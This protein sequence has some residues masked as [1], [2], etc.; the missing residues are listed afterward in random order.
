[1]LSEYELI[2]GL[3][4][5]KEVVFESIFREYYVRLCNFAYSFLEDKDE[6]EEV[7]QST[8]LSI[9]EK[10][11]NIDIQVSIKSYLY[12]AVHNSC[13]NRI[14]HGNVKSA[15]RER[16]KNDSQIF[17]EDASD[18]LISKEL[19]HQIEVAIDSLPP[20]C[21]MVFRL[22]RFENLSYA[23]I[24]DQMK[25]SVKTVENQMIKALKIL[26]VELKDYLP[27]LIWLLFMKK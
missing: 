13:L 24:A 14:K 1:M 23:E 8:F 7:V 20:K 10:H 9:W 4:S 17:T 5:G 15:H 25:I 11:D 21:G 2:Q 12:R 16:T 22:S 6:S 18:H 19:E 26:R 3:Q 27:A